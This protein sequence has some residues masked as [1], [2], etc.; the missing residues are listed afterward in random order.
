[1]DDTSVC[2]TWT[3]RSS[4]SSFGGGGDSVSIF[5]T[6]IDNV[7][8]SSS[9]F[10]GCWVLFQSVSFLISSNCFISVTLSLIPACSSFLVL[11]SWLLLWNAAKSTASFSVDGGSCHDASAGNATL[12][13]GATNTGIGAAK[14]EGVYT[15]W[16]IC[17]AVAVICCPFCIAS[18]TIASSNGGECLT[19][20][21]AVVVE[22]SFRSGKCVISDVPSS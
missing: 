11:L 4:S 3:G 10:F 8:Q 19:F 1:M 20:V 14:D 13:F 17:C 22:L 9:S 16:A 6:S 21:I 2:L 15:C 5:K 18:I 12:F 7:S